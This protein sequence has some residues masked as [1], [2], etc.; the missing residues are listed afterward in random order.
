MTKFKKKHLCAIVPMLISAGFVD[1][2]AQESSG[3]AL[4]E[5]VVMGIRQSIQAAQDVKRDATG[6]VDVV[7]SEDLGKF[8]DDNIGAAIGRIPGV[9]IQR[10]DNGIGGDRASI[11]GMGPLFVNTSVNGRTPL[12]HGDEGIGNIR[13]FNLDVIPAE[14]VSGVVVRKMPTAETIEGGIGGSVELKTLKPLSAEGLYKNSDV[15]GGVVSISGVNDSLTEEWSPKFS[16]VLGLRNADNTV[17]GYLSVVLSDSDYAV[18]EAYTRAQE[19]DI[20][21]DTNG[22]GIADRTEEDVISHSRIT[23]NAIRG[24]KERESFSYGIEWQATDDLKFGVDGYNSTYN[25][26]SQRPTVDLFFD[27]NGVF[28]EDAISIENNF[29]Q[30][31]DG[32]GVTNPGGDFKIENF[33]LLFDNL[34][35]NSVIGFNTVYG[36]DTAFTVSA[37]V[38]YSKVEFEQDLRLGIM[39]AYGLDPA[40][41]RY[42]GTGDVP[43]FTYGEEVNDVD[44]YLS[45]GF[46]GRDRRGNNEQLAFRMDFDL[47][48]NEGLNIK[49]GVRH[50]NT[51]IDVRET[52]RFTLLWD[53]ADLGAASFDGSL[54]EELFPGHDIGFNQFLVTDYD[55][56]A[57]VYPEIFNERA[58]AS[59]INDAFFAIDDS[60]GLP[61]DKAN[62]F[63]VEEETLAF[64]VQA[65]LEGEIGDRRYTANAGVR[66]VSTDRNVKGFQTTRIVNPLNAIVE[67]LGYIDTETDS[68][69]FQV[70]PSANFM[71]EVSES[72]QWRVG[73][74][75]TMSQPEYTDLKVNGSVNIQDVNDPGYDSTINSTA[76]IGNPDLE[77]YTAWSFD[78]TFEYY[79]D[80]GGAVFA[81]VFYKDVSNFVLREARTDVTIDGYDQLF[82]TTQPINVAKGDVKGFELGTNIPFGDFGIQANYT[83]V[84]SKFENPDNNPLLDNGFPG[85]SKHNFNAIGYYEIEAFSARMAYIYRDDYFQA[86]GGGFD[87]A[88]QPAFAEGSGQLDINLSYNVMENVQLTLDISNVTEE[89]ARN[90]INDSSN[91]RD[92]VTRPRTAVVGV[93]ASF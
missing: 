42:D 59:T 43:S 41:F 19:R 62:S 1:A 73:V 5:V 22:D 47:E 29:V 34:S 45:V 79:L 49:A 32:S 75:K 52:G 16:G 11:R 66:T 7:T 78:T 21:I 4:E 39:G 82:D 12:S 30:Q 85:S 60:T 87:R 92:Y 40:D 31:I 6:V 17:A 14:I 69:D 63:L 23:M 72:L 48:V 76:E 25:V 8:T 24:E 88:N 89:D 80:S 53:D 18:D 83:Y 37:D 28:D 10:N 13:Q 35:E 58:S 84:D 50:A 86:L 15:V 36:E 27:Y 90:Y 74:A 26:Y 81:S 2:Q 9:Q 65:D 64:Y 38:S 51:E 93:R 70:L 3:E 68:D 33:D 54:T 57:A 56:Q 55:A 46:F 44:S 20:Q 91:F 77:P 71:L 67:E 61:L